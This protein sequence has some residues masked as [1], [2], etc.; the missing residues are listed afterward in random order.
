MYKSYLP[1]VIIQNYYLICYFI[2][3]FIFTFMTAWDHYSHT[4]KSFNHSLFSILY[5]LFLYVLCTSG[6]LI[7]NNKGER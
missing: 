3:I 1:S 6:I 5:L 4:L 2:N 7:I